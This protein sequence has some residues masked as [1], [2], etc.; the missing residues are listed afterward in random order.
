MVKPGGGSIV[1]WGCC[2]SV[3]L[4]DYSEILQKKPALNQ[5]KKTKLGKNLYPI[6]GLLVQAGFSVFNYSF[7]KDQ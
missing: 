7:K 1:L 3:G 2:S 5:L 6:A 4:K